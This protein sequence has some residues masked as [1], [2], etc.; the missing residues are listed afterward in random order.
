METSPTHFLDMASVPPSDQDYLDKL[1][2]GAPSGKTRLCPK[3]NTEEKFYAVKDRMCYECGKCGYQIYPLAGTIMEKTRTELWKWFR[4]IN[5][6]SNSKNGVSTKEVQRTIKVTY[7]CAWRMC[8]LIRSLMKSGD[9]EK[10]T[11][12]MEV[13]ETY[14][15]GKKPS[16]SKGTGMENKTCVFGILQRN[17]EV[18]TF[19]VKNRDKKTLFPL[20]RKNVEK[21]SVV[22]SD[23]H[24]IYAAL[25]KEGYEHDF[26]CHKKYNWK[27]GE[28]STNAIEAHWS[29]VKRSIGGTYVHVSRKWLQ[30]Y[31]D[32]ASFRHNRRHQKGQIERDLLE[33]IY[34]SSKARAFTIL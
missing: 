12:T 13:D 30:Q 9:L 16:K 7:K 15:G 22:F 14:I 31:L 11:G 1:F 4:V 19:V 23:E 10:L 33:I 18:R 5:M 28:T 25:K 20:I 26:V 24:S 2:Y 6:F 29:V 34:Q 32:E 8:N 17:G 21:G 3:C 27:K